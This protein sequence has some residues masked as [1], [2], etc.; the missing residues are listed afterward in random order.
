M[1]FTLPYVNF[2]QYLTLQGEITKNIYT[3]YQIQRVQLKKRRD[4]VAN[5]DIK[6]RKNYFEAEL[7]RIK[8]L[9]PA[10]KEKIKPKMILPG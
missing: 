8:N 3:L 4:L 2:A 10:L 7:E 1:L 6:H 5:G 9:P